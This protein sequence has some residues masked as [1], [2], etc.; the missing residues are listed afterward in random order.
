MGLKKNFSSDYV[1]DFIDELISDTLKEGVE[2]VK[3]NPLIIDTFDDVFHEVT[4][5]IPLSGIRMIKEELKIGKII[6]KKMT[7]EIVNEITNN[8]YLLLRGNPYFSPND[9]EKGI[10]SIVNRYNTFKGKVCA[11]FKMFG[12]ESIVLKVA[13]EECENSLDLLRLSSI[14]LQH[15]NH[16]INITLEGEL[17]RGYQNTLFFKSNFKYYKLSNELKGHIV[18]F[19]ISDSEIK[20]MKEFGIFILSKI[21]EKPDRELT[22]FERTLLMGVHWFANFPSQKEIENQYL[23]LMVSLEIFLTPKAGS[24]EPISN[25]IAEGASII[26]EIGID[27]RKKLKSKIKDLYKKRSSIVHGSMNNIPTEKDIVTLKNILLTLI[28]WMIQNSHRFD[29]KD[30]LLDFIEDHKFACDIL[31]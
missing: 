7:D 1:R 13:K 6:I 15:K 3:D 21:L 26:N 20:Y 14:Y 24:G 8:L 29:N 27:N 2:N 17:A 12:E 18:D 4:V 31:T 23:S 10:Q 28:W 9:K 11:E 19:N 25:Y 5:Y 16:N 30:D 22:D